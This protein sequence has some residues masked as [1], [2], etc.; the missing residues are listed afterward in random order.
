MTK[1]HLNT[2]TGIEVISDE[3]DMAAYVQ[4]GRGERGKSAFVLRPSSTEEVVRCIQHCAANNIAYVPQSGNTGLVGAS[5][6]DNSGKTA[7]LSLAKVRNTFELDL[8]NRSLTVSAG[9]RLS[10]INERLHDNGLFFPIDLSSDPMIGGMVATNT[11]GG[12]FIKYGDVRR[13]VLGL[14]VVLNTPEADVLQLGSS[15]RKT[16]TGP[17]WKHNYIGT[18]GWFGVITEVTLNLEAMV[19]DQ[20]TA[21]VVPQ[22]SASMLELLLHMERR[23]GPL[24]SAFEFMSRRALQRTFEHTPALSNPF[25]DAAIPENAVLVELSRT[26]LNAAWDTPLEE[27]LQAV[28]SEALESENA[29]IE[30]AIFG[31]PE[32][33]WELRHTMSYG[34]MAAGPLV[35]FD[36]GFTREQVIHFRAMMEENMPAKFPEIEICDFGH[37]GDGGLHFNLI[38][39]DGPLT[40]E[41]ERNLRDWVVSVAVEQFGASYSAEHAL[42][43]RNIHYFERYSALEKTVL[44][45]QAGLFSNSGPAK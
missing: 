9:F 43:P 23:A 33:I 11:G 27:V 37:L 1:D 7:V 17:D 19:Q 41:F 45:R 21:I 25:A 26:T 24:L 44:K 5:I 10:E 36:L 13:N 12:R 6:P 16:S 8:A 15:V 30:D 3:H 18:S 40:A 2:P 35:A 31:R 32:K 14:R 20:A 38:K 39:T 28:L 42:G 34:V 22:S 4:G 29:L